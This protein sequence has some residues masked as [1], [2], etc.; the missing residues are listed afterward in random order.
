LLTTHGFGNVLIHVNSFAV[1]GRV[2]SESQ[3]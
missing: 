2:T 1:G 3:Q